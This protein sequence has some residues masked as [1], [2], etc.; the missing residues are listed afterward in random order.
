MG[1]Q[2]RTFNQFHD[3]AGRGIDSLVCK[4]PYLV[5]CG[6]AYNL[7]LVCNREYLIGVQC[8]IQGNE[9]QLG[10]KGIFGGKKFAGAFH[11]LEI[12]TSGK[13]ESPGK[14]I[15]HLIDVPDIG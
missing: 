6:I 1:I 14:I 4:L 8:G 10:V 7:V 9:S 2:G 11:F 12:L 3:E 13:V 15:A 5:Y